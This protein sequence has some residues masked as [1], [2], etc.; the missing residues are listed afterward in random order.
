MGYISIIESAERSPRAIDVQIENI[1]FLFFSNVPLARVRVACINSHDTN[2][3]NSNV[4]EQF[5]Q[6]M[7]SKANVTISD[8]KSITIDKQ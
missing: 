1:N 3:F 7:S 6:Q 4:Y 8:R 5:K 2:I